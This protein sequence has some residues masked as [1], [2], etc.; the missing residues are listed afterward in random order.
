MKWE[1][2]WQKE[3]RRK[4]WDPKGIQWKNRTDQWGQLRFGLVNHT[5]HLV[6]KAME[7]RGQ[8]EGGKIGVMCSPSERSEREN[9]GARHIRYI[10]HESPRPTMPWPNHR[11]LCPAAPALAGR[12][13]SEATQHFRTRLMIDL[14]FEKST[15]FFFFPFSLHQAVCGAAAALGRC[16]VDVLLGRLDGAGLKKNKRKKI[17]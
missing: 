14:Y 11:A 6:H 2:K 3:Q 1:R 13:R 16:P 15:T 17:K 8:K 9:K 7:P 10:M 4:K 5:K 12:G